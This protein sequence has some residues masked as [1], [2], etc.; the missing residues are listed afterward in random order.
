MQDILFKANSGQFN[1]D[2][3]QGIV[4]CF[5][6]GIGN[7][8]SVG[9][10][11]VTGAFA[12][13]LQRRKPR[14]VWGHNWNDP[15]GK[16][17]E[18]YEVP[19]NDPRLPQKMKM[20]GIGG[21]Y[22]KVQFNLN[23][24]KGKEAF[25]NVAFFGEEQEWSIGYKTLDAVFDN[26]KQ[27]NLLREVELYELSP[28]L[29]GANQLTGTISVKTDEKSHDMMTMPTIIL[30][31]KPQQPNDPFA[32]G[33]AQ[34]VE[35][36]RLIA[37][38]NELTTRTGG[39]I[40]VMK[41][42]ES[43]VVFLKPG[44]GMYRLGYYF[45]GEEYMFGKPEKLSSPMMV[46]RPM[47]GMTRP[48]AEPRQMERIPNFPRVQ[49]KPQSSEGP[50]VPV[51]YGDSNVQS[52]LFDSLKSLNEIFEEKMAE[53]DGLTNKLRGIVSSLQNIIGHETEEK[54]AW[55]IPCKIENL[56]HT[57]D[58]I[59]PVLDYHRIES[60]VT[61]E[62]I[63]LISPM[64]YEAFEAVDTAT[65]NLM[66]RI[67]R[68]LAPGGGGKVRRARGALSR[69]E[70]I[71]D[72]RTRRD[73]DGD[74]LIF[75]GT[76]R[77]MPDPTRFTNRMGG[78]RSETS[79]PD[80]PQIPPRTPAQQRAREKYKKRQ[81][82][83]L[84][85]YQ[86][87]A[88]GGREIAPIFINRQIRE[89]LNR[90]FDDFFKDNRLP[91]DHIISRVAKAIKEAV[92]YTEMQQL[93]NEVGAPTGGTKPVQTSDVL[94][95]I[96]KKMLEELK[97]VWPQV[98]DQLKEM[99]RHRRTESGAIEKGQSSYD[100]FEK[101]VETGE[102]QRV[103]KVNMK[104]SPPAKDPVDKLLEQATSDARRRFGRAKKNPQEPQ[105]LVG[106]VDTRAG[107][108][109]AMSRPREKRLFPIDKNGKELTDLPMIIRDSSVSSGKNIIFQ[110]K[111]KDLLEPYIEA[112]IFPK[113]W[114]E[115][116][117][118]QQWK[119][120]TANRD[121]LRKKAT[122]P[123]WK[124]FIRRLDDY[125]INETMKLD[126]K[127]EVEEFRR[128]R[129]ANPTALQPP[130]ASPTPVAVS[131]PKKPN[132]RPKP[133]DSDSRDA[134]K[135]NKLKNQL[136]KWSEVVAVGASREGVE[137][138]LREALNDSADRILATAFPDDDGI[139]TA[140]SI[141]NALD[142][143]DEALS[144]L[145]SVTGD[146]KLSKNE[147]AL[148]NFFPQVR[149]FLEDYE[150]TRRAD[151]E[152][153]LGAEQAID[154][155]ARRGNRMDDLGLGDDD[156][157]VVGGANIDEIYGNDSY[158]TEEGFGEIDTSDNNSRSGLPSST[159]RPLSSSI[160]KAK[161]YQKEHRRKKQ[162]RRGGLASSTDGKVPRTEIIT[163]STWWQKIDESLPAEIK[164]ADSGSIRQGLT[165]LQQKISKYDA[166]AFRPNS[167]RTNVGSI[168]ISADEADQIL[169]AVMA[170]ID[171]QRT[172]GKGGTAGTRG[173]IFAELL[174]KISSAAM[175]TFV[176]KT[177]KPVDA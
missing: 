20:A 86:E 47:N 14:V 111:G 168:K 143:I 115:M 50:I 2:E 102:F 117:V 176:D 79:K 108:R 55:M 151:T 158:G 123:Q 58:A 152:N 124:V 106:G 18:I 156:D 35:G 170:V 153:D 118:E 76:W 140:E 69:I 138:D 114:R 157:D 62:G 75:D 154:A 103:N 52:G 60:F 95:D 74:G 12:K 128:N 81:K 37:L 73:I 134:V 125:L 17:L 22:A 33:I 59:D 110:S 4:E 3:A 56:F 24:E 45:D 13:S 34:P 51:K 113:N 136:T 89:R 122:S 146:R 82:G 141:A 87:A 80:D 39:P 131:E 159:S 44:K 129:A 135:A 127:R 173:E 175:S 38:T 133:I 36:D 65:K 57:K 67:G 171:R 7:K 28:V 164:K 119:W 139:P 54:S 167:K 49:G 61:E 27:A 98:K 19:P 29:H 10:I 101:I 30:E 104:A 85:W 21:L 68:G 15:I 16:V 97:T 105:R 162:G 40:K 90:M 109:S 8:D 147:R 107:K 130:T 5:V 92:R 88:K 41:A 93:V 1:I 63:V 9:D 83:D 71:L 137:D 163:E 53:D 23:S 96:D 150:G 6:A 120:M 166:G 145:G 132:Y 160:S 99:G 121:D 100:V 78:L 148:I 26:S 42:T 155:L 66:G 112:G 77:E 46:Q 43:S 32:Q 144:E 142:G 70:G 126:E 91:E 72:P 31:D 11:C 116:D 161:R 48:G 177:S 165:L 64:D 174:E 25:T 172:A 84:L 149:D 94:P 169:D